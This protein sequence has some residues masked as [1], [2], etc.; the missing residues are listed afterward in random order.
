LLSL[1]TNFKG[2]TRPGRLTEMVLLAGQ[3]GRFA[4]KILLAGGKEAASPTPQV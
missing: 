2:I 4:E 3:T 1:Q